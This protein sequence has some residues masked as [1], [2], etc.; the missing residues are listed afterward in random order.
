M[1]YDDPVLTETQ[2]FEYLRFERNLVGVT[3]RS[4]KMAV[5]R[6]EIIP[7]R[8][9]NGNWFSRRDGDD[10]IKSR[11]QPE[12]SRFV[13]VHAGLAPKSAAAQSKS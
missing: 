7:T 1:N 6:R 3:R 4:V 11:K 9:G 2:L 5:Q 12:P 13:G 8:L 10:W